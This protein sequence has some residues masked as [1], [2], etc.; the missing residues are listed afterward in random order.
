M[1]V[2]LCTVDCYL[3]VDIVGYLCWLLPP[4]KEEVNVF[5]R[6]RLSVCLSVCK[7]TQKRMRGFGWN[8]V[9]R[10]MSGHGQTNSL[11][12][13]IRVIVRMLEPDCFLRYRIG[14]GTLQPCLGC[15]RAVWL[16]E[17][18]RPENPTYTYWRPAATARRGFKMVLFTE[19]A[20]DLRRR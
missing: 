3:L 13:P 10:Q 16:C 4:T 20:E 6:V 18:L 15:Q 19:P 9:Y 1:Y 8:V 5:S 14:Y 12:S 17:I 7:I 11:L 2:C